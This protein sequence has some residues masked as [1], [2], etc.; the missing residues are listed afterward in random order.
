V[1]YQAGKT[2]TAAE[3]NRD[4]GAVFPSANDTF[5]TIKVLTADTKTITAIPTH[6]YKISYTTRHSST[7]ASAVTVDARWIAGAGPITTTS[8]QIFTRVFQSSGGN[9]TFTTFGTLPA[10]VLSGLVTIGFTAF[11]NTGTITFYGGAGEREL[12]IE[13]LGP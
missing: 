4:M 10:G 9:E 6:R 2:L 8:T 1:S 12:L 3:L 7:A 5:T 13:D 11:T